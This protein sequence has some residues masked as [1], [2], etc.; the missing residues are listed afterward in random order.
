VTSLVVTAD[1]LDALA[2]RLG[3]TGFPG[4]CGSVFDTVGAEHH[5][6]LT[7][8]LL[9]TL[10]AR[11]LIAERADRLVA[12][13]DVALLLAPTLHG[14][15]RYEVERVEPHQRSTTA[16]GASGSTV[17]W[18][19]ADGPYHRFDLVGTDGDVA[20]VLAAL[21]DPSPGPSAPEAR[22]F[23]GRQ[24]RLASAG[25]RPE[26][27]P[28]AFAALADGWRA[29]TTLTQVGAAAGVPAMSWLTVIDGGAG[30]VW[31]TEPDTES[32][33]DNDPHCVVTPVTPECLNRRLAAWCGS[34]APAD[35]P[36]R[37]TLDSGTRD[38]AYQS[39]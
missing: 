1:E 20:A 21:L 10:A 35:R 22:Q 26:A 31:L 6:T 39:P 36:R 7:A 5:R 33:D 32:V 28:A 17:V 29:T 8:A 34:L 3:A 27:V 38:G 30:R 37:W 12:R 19:R 9:A 13:P 14:P 11:G 25:S 4:V 23:R 24:S 2:R 18:H 15:V 16:V